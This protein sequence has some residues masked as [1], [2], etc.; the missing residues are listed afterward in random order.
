MKMALTFPVGE[1]SGKGGG[2][3][4]LVYFQWRGLQVARRMVQPSNPQTAEQQGMRGFMTAAAVAFQSLTPSEKADWDAWAE[5]NASQILGQDVVRPAISEYCGV[6][7][8]RQ[9]AGAAIDDAAPTAKTDFA[10]TGITSVTNTGPG[11][12]LDIVFTHN[13]SVTTNRKVLVRTTLALASQL[14]VPKKSDYR[15]VEG[16]LA[17][18]SV[19]ALAASP[20]TLVFTSPWNFPTAATYIGVQIEPISSEYASG[21][22][23]S[24]VVVVS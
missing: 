24:D 22:Q 8:V 5:I 23:F 20:Q 11:T 19:V 9:I 1:L 4:G 12:S 21:V 13:A 17:G 15:T 18:G 7:C 3:F 16:V 2:P 6:N 10:I 14:V